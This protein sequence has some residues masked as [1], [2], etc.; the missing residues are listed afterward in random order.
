MGG[1]ESFVE[2]GRGPDDDVHAGVTGKLFDRQAVTA[3][4][5]SNT[6]RTDGYLKTLWVCAGQGWSL[7]RGSRR[8]GNRVALKG[9]T[10]VR[11]LVKAPVAEF[12]VFHCVELACT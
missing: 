1:R 2:I 11:G 7:S 12:G 8:C 5:P 3:L 4:E 6:G 10:Y 9:L